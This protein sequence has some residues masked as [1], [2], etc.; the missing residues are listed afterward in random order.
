MS[1]RFD[2]ATDR[3]FRTDAS[4]PNPGSGITVLGWVRLSVDTGNFATICRLSNS[5]GDSTAVT[6]STDN[7]GNT[8]AF[9]TASGSIVTTFSL[10]VGQ[11]CRYAFTQTGTAGQ[12]YAGTDAG[13][14]SLFSGSVNGVANPNVITFGGRSPGDAVEYGDVALAYQRCFAS[15]LTGAQIAAELASSSAV[16]SSWA[17]WPLLTHTDLTDHSGNGRH[18]TAGSTPTTT[19]DDPPLAPAPSGAGTRFLPFIIP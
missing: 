6:F 13:S 9:F 4:L 5:A 19:E 2:A 14:L 15:V 10:V 1:N 8:L 16:L 12:V 7:D 3:I 11:W 17:D 18:L